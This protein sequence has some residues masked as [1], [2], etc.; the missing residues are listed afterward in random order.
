MLTVHAKKV[1]F[2]ESRL[3][4]IKLA[5]HFMGVRYFLCMGRDWILLEYFN[6]IA[7]PEH[8]HFNLVFQLTFILTPKGSFRLV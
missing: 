3:I 5:V 7:I 8:L 4:K 2:F 1:A 6:S